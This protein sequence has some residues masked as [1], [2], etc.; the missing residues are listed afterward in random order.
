[1][2]EFAIVQTTV[3]SKENV[4]RII[5]ALLNAK[6]IAC[7]NIIKT[8]SHYVWNNAIQNEPEFIVIFKTKKSD[9][10]D[11]EKLII[12]HHDYEVPQVT[13]INIDKGSNTY[14]N[15]INEVTR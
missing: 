15:W 7:A 5:S 3:G 14:L 10:S 11:I 1:M 8:E 9:Y 12:E 6:L 13:S 2:T 4:D